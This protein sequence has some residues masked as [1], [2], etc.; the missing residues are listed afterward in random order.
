MTRPEGGSEPQSAA[1]PTQDLLDSANELAGSN[2][3][4]VDDEAVKR[5]IRAIMKKYAAPGA[6]G[7]KSY[8]TYEEP[9]RGGKGFAAPLEEPELRIQK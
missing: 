9:K 5:K 4:E 7:G 2:A 8:N 1:D 6:K 3:T